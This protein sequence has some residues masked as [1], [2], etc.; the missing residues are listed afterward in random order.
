VPI[1]SRAIVDAVASHAAASGH[2]DSAVNKHEPKSPPGHGLSA[3]VWA[4]RLR[5][6]PAA[7]GL[8]STSAL[9]VLNLRVQAGMLQEPQDDIDPY[10]LDAVDALMIAY[11]GDFTLGGLVRNVDLLG[12]SGVALAAEAGYLT[13]GGQQGGMYRVMVITIPMIIND[14]WEQ[15]A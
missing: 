2:F 14:A 12:Q 15:S 11:S 10:I 8:R 13:I 5:P 3:S 4:Q 7:S 6:V 1:D 9:L